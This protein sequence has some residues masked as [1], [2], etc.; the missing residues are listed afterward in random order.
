[1]EHSGAVGS[2]RKAPPRSITPEL[3]DLRTSFAVERRLMPALLLLAVLTSF[4]AMGAGA[5]A[6][7]L[8]W[9]ALAAVN[10]AIRF[11]VA[12]THVDAKYIVVPESSG[13]RL[14][15]WTAVADLVLWA[16][17]LALVP[18]PA[19]FLAGSG[20]FAAVGAVLM[21]ALSYGGWPRVWTFYVAA[22]VGIFCIGVI[23]APGD[24]VFGLAFPLWLLA[25]W[26]I[27]RQQP[28]ARHGAPKPPQTLISNPTKFGWQAAIHAMPT[29]VIVA[30]NGRVIEVNRPACEF[31][32]RAEPSIV[33]NSVGQS[34]VAEPPG[35]LDPTEHPSQSSVPVEVRAAHRKP[36]G[37]TWNGRVR[38]MEPGR[39]TS[40]MVIALTE[41]TKAAFGPERL[42]DDAQRFAE[43]IG[44]LQGLPWFRD[45][46]GR[47][48][49]PR[50]FPAPADGPLTPDPHGFPLAYLIPEAD[51]ARVNSQYRTALRSGAVFDECMQ[52][53]DTKG[54]VRNVRVVCMTRPPMGSGA[55]HSV[56]GTLAEARSGGASGITDAVGDLMARLPVLVWLV[57]A[58]GRLVH[59]Q[60]AEPRRW[61]LRA[62]PRLRPQWDEA[63]EF[64]AE[65]RATVMNGIQKALRGEP[66]FDV[67]NARTSRSGG[68]LHLRSHFVPYAGS[69]SNAV[70]VLDTIASPTELLEIEKL[71]RSK[72][73][74]KSLVEA[75]ASLIWACDQSFTLTF[76]S[77]RAARDIYGYE[78][79]ELLGRPV[80]S[81]LP[82]DVEQPAVKD[83]FEALREGKP[84]RDLEAVHMTQDGRRVIVSIS[85]VPMR[86]RDGRL[87]GVIGMNADLT[88]LKSREGR[89]SEALRVERTVLDSAGQAIA[90]VKQGVVQRC[91]DAFLRLAGMPPDELARVPVAGALLDPQDWSEVTTAAEEARSRDQAIV[92]ELRVK[93][94][95]TLGIADSAWCQVTARSI[96]P[97]EYVLVI[98][99]IDTL[100]QREAN[101]LH[102]AQHDDLT[103][104]PNRR[105]LAERAAA[106]LATSELR[107]VSC[108]VIAIDLDGFKDI[109]D[110]HG[111]EI[112]DL[113]LREI[114]VRLT[115]VMRPQDTVARRGGDE[116]AVLVPDVGSTMEVEKIAERLLSAIAQPASLAGAPHAMNVSASIGI[117]LA[118]EQGRDLERLLQLADLA[119]YDAKLKGK[120]RYSFAQGAT[121]P[122]KVRP[123]VPRVSRSS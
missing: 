38:F 8:G 41:E 61:G 63:F 2:S 36:P 51:R 115:R 17:M 4:A 87:A 101:A 121:A 78:T 16:A 29:P 44:G 104:L 97:H 73:Q 37:A 96:A 32:G 3:F 6:F 86:H 23:R 1:M 106:A 82:T 54:G 7:A 114:A 66:V 59:A 71:R 108:A 34:I 58:Q 43:W 30:R 93:R 65:S 74:Y 39:S 26:W 69:K 53:R 117:A 99:D 79:R 112:G 11:L 98:A 67:V 56:I 49:V 60:G 12:T 50:E 88:A 109:N 52:V 20:G 64:K 48:V 47:L 72:A 85:A 111:H 94:S 118:P 70:M 21:G 100:K 55:V 102:E 62:E 27:G 35:A 68:R 122:F 28:L 42:L 89:L 107:R 80:D 15:F 57:D 105:L 116:F 18:K 13:G 103:G 123:L 25:A 120:N 9:L 81:L 90:V 83:A 22:W 46:K 45:E 40:V 91:N 31:I 95:K 113:M 14:Y 77:R 33:G 10:A 19:V 5:D 92:R 76:V 24:I 110:R 75:S 119:M 84:I